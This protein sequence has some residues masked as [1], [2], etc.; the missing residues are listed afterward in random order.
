MKVNDF[1][2]V[3]HRTICRVRTYI[4]KDKKYFIITELNENQGE[5][6]TNC[7]E[8]LIKSLIKQGYA[9]SDDIF[10]EHNQKILFM[11]E[12]FDEIELDEL[13]N[14][15]WYRRT[16]K[17]VMAWID[18]EISSF[19]KDTEKKQED[20]INIIKTQYKQLEFM[21]FQFNEDSRISKRRDE[22][23]NNMISKNELLNLIN[24]RPPE[25]EISDMVKRDLS[26]FAELYAHPAEEYICFSE[27]NFF[28]KRVDFVLFTGRSSMKVYLIEIKGADK[29]ILK[30][31]NYNAFTYKFNEAYAQLNNEFDYINKNYELIRRKM[32]EVREKAINDEISCFKG[33]KFD[34]NVDPN[35]NVIFYGVIICGYTENNLLESDKRH[36]LEKNHSNKII[37]ETWDSFIN[38][39]T[40]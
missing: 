28:D 9:K 38:K 13:D 27:F 37:V 21:N 35:K 22:I 31:N 19:D 3:Y 10:I 39:L 24:T 6:I 1:I 11:D 36:N 12:E 40:R 26:I 32:H 30:K 14:P 7:I 23:R 29:R 5:S 17:E 34:L 33:P 18:E 16:K 8:H 25:S 15:K 2:H 4:N 20:K